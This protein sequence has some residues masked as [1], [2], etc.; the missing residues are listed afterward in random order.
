MYLLDTN[1]ISELR[2]PKPH[3]AVLAWLN[4]IPDTDLFVSAVTMGELQ[5]G[6]ERTRK[7][8]PAKSA[9]LELWADQIELVYE[10]LPVTA[11]IF[12]QWARLT[13]GKVGGGYEDAMIAAT[14]LVHGLTMVTRDV[15][16]FERFGVTILNPFNGK[17]L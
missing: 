12:R 4:A 2:R 15:R 8:D 7:T 13:R 11:E 5:S 3:G 16:D 1:V 14:A 17:V 9:A 6:I 10:A